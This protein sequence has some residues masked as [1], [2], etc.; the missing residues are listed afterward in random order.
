LGRIFSIDMAGFYLAMVT[1]TFIHGALVDA[2]GGNQVRLIALGT[3]VVNFIPLA[4]WA[5]ITRWLERRQLAAQA[6]APIGD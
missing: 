2:L 3:M 5:L 4:A 1:S 6:V